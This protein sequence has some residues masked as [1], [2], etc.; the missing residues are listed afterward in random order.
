MPAGASNDRAGAR[1]QRS[2][3]LAT[4]PATRAVTSTCPPPWPGTSRHDDLSRR[5]GEAGMLALVRPLAS[6]R[7]GFALLLA[8]SVV[9]LGCADVVVGYF[10]GTESTSASE[11]SEAGTLTASTTAADGTTLD[12]TTVGSTADPTG[13][14][15]VPPG[16]FA[17]DFADGVVDE[18]R[19]NTWA[20]A[21]SSLEETGG[22]LKLTPPTYGLF[23]TGVVGRFD[24]HF[25]FEHGWVRL[26]AVA[27][28]PVDRPAGLFLMVT[29]E[30]E[31]LS[32]RLAG[33]TVEVMGAVGEEQVVFQQSF[34]A[35]PYPAFI[36]IRGEGSV[37]HFEVSTDGETWSTLATYDK[38]GPF[39]E[40]TALIMAQTFGDYPDRTT[41]TVDDFEAC[42]Q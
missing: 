11:P 29:A 21:D 39:A 9:P 35:S 19:W 8:A 7:R 40:A 17:D 16:C 13:E 30:P 38:P 12:P 23:D 25:A 28:P 6:T 24:H 37:A 27:P 32:I 41:V 42:V 3:G 4:A 33:G 10:S 22:L 18:P 15:F 31:L 36:G 34:P 14:G 26:R 1:P 5:P 20:E 2:G